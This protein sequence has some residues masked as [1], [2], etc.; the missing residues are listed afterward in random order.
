M[1]VP[2]VRHVAWPAA[3]RHSET[4]YA[5]Q[6]TAGASD[7]RRVRATLDQTS[8]HRTEAGAAASR[9]Y[10]RG[11]KKSPEGRR[12]APARRRAS[13]RRFSFRRIIDRFLLRR[14]ISVVFVPVIYRE[15]NLTSYV[16]L[17]TFRTA[18]K[19]GFSGRGIFGVNQGRERA[20]R[21]QFPR[22]SWT[23]RFASPSSSSRGV[24]AMPSRSAGATS[25]RK[26][27]LHSGR[28]GVRVAVVAP[29]TA[30]ETRR[31]CAHGSALL[32]QFPSQ[33][34]LPNYR[35]KHP[36][37]GCAQRSVLA[38]RAGPPVS[39]ARHHEGQS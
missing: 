33:F 15:W 14:A 3:F 17:L 36:A 28:S 12:P 27:H 18:R 2:I 20:V 39:A 11:I 9:A 16:E 5:I 21:R 19:R 8:Q 29:N 1:S 26:H 38:G 7:P 35:K 13:S 10:A 24:C 31:R 6:S 23:I 30:Y 32:V 37:S 34:L 4:S 25:R 22:K